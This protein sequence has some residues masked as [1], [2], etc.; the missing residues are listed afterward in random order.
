MKELQ[1]PTVMISRLGLGE[2]WNYQIIINKARLEAFIQKLPDLQKDETYYLCLFARS[3]Y[4][5]DIAHISSD[6]QQCKR[7]TSDKMRMVEKILQLEIPK[8]RYRQKGN[9]LP[10]EALALYINPNPRSFSKAAKAS[11]K[12]FADLVTR[13]YSGYNPHQEVMSEIQKAKSR[14]VYMDFDFDNAPMMQ[15]IE[16]VLKS[17]N[18]NAVNVLTTR[19]GFHILIEVDKVEPEYR[20]TWYNAIKAIPGCDVTGDN[21]IPVPGCY[22]GGFVPEFKTIF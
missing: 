15:T 13:E 21:M 11:L 6:K 3:K 4:A 1:E 12:T 2:S 18:R 19:G 22:Q 5:K 17:V 10:Q 8:G 20:R 16:T 9:E 7:F 14:T